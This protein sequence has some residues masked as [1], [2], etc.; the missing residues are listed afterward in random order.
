M[1]GDAAPLD[2]SGG[3]R[4][5][6]IPSLTRLA[7]HGAWA[8]SRL[9]AAARKA[10]GDT[11][12]VLRE[13]A[14]VRAAQ[15]IW[16]AR[17]AGRAPT[18]PVWPTLT[19]DELATRGAVLDAALLEALAGLTADALGREVVYAN[20]SGTTFRTPV[21]DVL[22]HLLTHGQYHR[23]KANSALRAIGAEAVNVDFI[24]WQR[25]L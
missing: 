22:L 13:L 17:I 12:A 9:L 7:T 14:H 8:D 10:D 18:L 25:S 4:A 23:G 19:L 5:R 6:V 20:S 1:R 3:R 16:L 21:A 2:R 11:T 24:T 15:D